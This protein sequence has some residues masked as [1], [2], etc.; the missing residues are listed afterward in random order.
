M[1][2][3]S[4]RPMALA[5]IF[6]GSLSLFQDAAANGW[7][8]HRFD[9]LRAYHGDWLNVCAEKGKG[10]CRTVQTYVPKGGDRFFGESKLTVYVESSGAVSLEIFDAGMPALKNVAIEFDFGDKRVSVHPQYWQLGG[11]GVSNLLETI[12]IP[13]GE[14]ATTLVSFI[15][16]K[17]RLR[18]KYPGSGGG[19]GVA[20]FSLRGS[21]AALAS[22]KR[23]LASRSP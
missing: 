6:L 22:I 3:M 5:L 9:E 17:N 11:K 7:F 14:V 2:F 18:V 12:Y 19:D 20:P 1:L 4:A 16:A 23:H 10:P 21:S 15:R 8:I 13:P